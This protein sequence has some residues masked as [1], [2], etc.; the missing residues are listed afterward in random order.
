M[1]RRQVVLIVS[2]MLAGL[3]AG[4]PLGVHLGGGSWM[5]AREVSPD[6]TMAV[7]FYRPARW[8]RLPDMRLELASFVRLASLPDDETLGVSP[9]V[10]LDGN[11]NVRW[12]R[13]GVQ[14]GM[15]IVCRR[16]GGCR[17]VPN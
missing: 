6:G 9:V 2:G 10:N 16:S 7:Q 15:N 8:R 5:Y 17:Y 11:G 12:Q 14:V 1:A 3:T 13:D 4:L